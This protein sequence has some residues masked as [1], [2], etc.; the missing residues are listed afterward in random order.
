MPAY[1]ASVPYTRS[2][3]VGW[4]TDSCTC[5]IVC[6]G[7]EDDRR[8]SGRAL[9]RAQERNCLLADARR[10]SVEAE[11]LDELPAALPA[12]PGVLARI[13]P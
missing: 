5:M 12:D 11:L 1:A 4:P 2:S 13:A 8:L 10:L 7:V 6:S 9:G 3:S